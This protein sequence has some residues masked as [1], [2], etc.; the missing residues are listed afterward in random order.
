MKNLILKSSLMVALSFAVVGTQKA[1][2]TYNLSDNFS[3]RPP[4]S[5]QQECPQAVKNIDPQLKPHLEN[6][7]EYISTQPL[8][9]QEY[10]NGIHFITQCRKERDNNQVRALERERET[11]VKAM[12]CSNPKKELALFESKNGISLTAAEAEMN[13]FESSIREGSYSL[14]EDP[15]YLKLKATV[16]NL[17]AKCAADEKAKYKIK[18]LKK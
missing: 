7:V 16:L 6:L 18:S 2:N 14:T 1:V 13:A 10:A 5:F 15:R 8:P 3:K 12:G 4:K 9:P 17:R 11:E